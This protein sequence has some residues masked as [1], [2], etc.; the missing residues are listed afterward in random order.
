MDDRLYQLLPV[1]Y[2]EHDA[3]RGY[4]LRAVLRVIQEQADILERDVAQLWDDAFIET[5]RPWVI[6]YIGDLVSNRLL[7]DASRVT[8]GQAESLFLDLTGPDLKPPIAIR[9]RADVAKTIYYR[10]RKSTLP[11][12]EELTRDVTG[13]PAHAVEFFELLGWT[14]HLEHLRFQSQ[15][16]DLRS[17]DRMDRIDGA[18]DETSHTVDVRKIQRDEGWHHVR[19]IGLFLFRLG[20]YELNDVPARVGSADWR[21]HFSPLG[22]AAPIFTRWRREGDPSGLATELHV[23]APIRRAFYYE[24]LKRYRELQPVRPNF[25]DLYGDNPEASF[26]IRRNGSIVLPTA[27]PNAPP[28]V[29]VPQLVCHQLDPWPATQP[30]GQIVAVDPQSGRIAVGDGWPDATLSIDVDYHYGFPADLGGGPYERHKWLL[31]RG[32]A[33]AH[34]FVREGAPPTAD[35]FPS[36]LLAIQEWVDRG[37]PDTLITLLDSRSYALPATLTLPNEGFLVIEAASGVRP[38]LATLAAGLDIDTLPPAIP[39]DPTRE[40]ALTLSGVVI[41]GHL[42]VIGDLALLRLLH[43]TLVP[44]RRLIEDGAPE[45]DAPSILVEPGVAGAELNTELK[46]HLAF[47]ICGRLELP[48]HAREVRLLDSILDGLGADLVAYGDG[49]GGAGPELHL[50]RTTVFGGVAARALSMSESIASGPITVVRTQEGCVRFSYLVPGSH[51]PRRHRCQPD[52]AATKAIEGAEKHDPGLTLAE[53]QLL[54]SFIESAVVPSFVSER[55]GQPAYAQLRAVV[56]AELTTGSE[57]GSEMGVYCHLK[58]PQRLD[59]LRLRLDE[60]LPFGLDAG[61]ITIT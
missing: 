19:N 34:L 37:Q 6:P 27:N 51:T 24:D 21:Y 32:L 17:V 7:F 44:G 20:A 13:W 36:L 61:A 53:R 18:F 8:A 46:V 59:N 40:A 58:Q 12:L 49:A 10:R 47:S 57:D 15:F 48:G 14:Q 35:T 11:M 33:P 54:R 56:P 28:S 50:D 1:V 38:V 39:S 41:E 55:Y 22:Q 5:C 26:S 23:P 2:R 9:T 60:Y 31:R 16:A 52:L 30:S 42:H 3:A 45:S 4:P 43:A 29:F 25:T